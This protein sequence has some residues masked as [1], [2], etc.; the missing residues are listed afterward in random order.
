LGGV[1]RDRDQFAD[2]YRPV[3][4]ARYPVLL[5]RTPYN[6]A[7]AQTCVYQHPAWYA[8][9][10]YIV[11]VQDTR[12]RF[13]SGGSFE[14]Y[15][16]E[17]KDGVDTIAWASTLP[18]TT[19]QV[20]TYGFSY[21]GSNQLVA[22]GSNPKGLTSAAIGCAGSDFYDGWTYRG[23]ALQLAFVLSW[24]LHAFAVPD[25]LKAQDR[26]RA[27]WLRELGG[28]MRAAYERPLAHWLRSKQ[29]PNYFKDWVEHDTRDAYWQALAP[30]AT[31]GTINIP[32]LH[33]SGWYDIF[34]EGSIA[35]YCELRRGSGDDPSRQ[36]ALVIGPWQ[37]VPWA[38]LNGAVDYGWAGDN[39]VDQVQ[40][41][42]FDHWLK[43]KTVDPVFPTVRFFLLGANQWI[44]ADRWP[45]KGAYLF[46]LYLRSSGSAGTQLEDGGLS[47]EPP[48]EE[49][50][51]IFVYDPA[52]PVPSIGGSSCC[53]ADVAPIGVFDQR[54]VEIR[55]D[56]LVYTSA[57]LE[58][59][60]D[61]IG[62]LDLVLFAAS[63]AVDTD[64]TAKLVD[65]HPD[66]SALNVCD[67][68]IRARYRRSLE[69]STL[70]EPE[71]V[72]QYRISLRAIAMRFAAGLAMRLE[73]S[74][75]SFP[76]YNVNPNTGGRMATTDPLD[77][78]LATQLVF[79]DRH[80]QSRLR[81]MLAEGCHGPGVPGSRRG[82]GEWLNSM[83]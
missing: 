9:H 12:G 52:N 76:A 1:I 54:S 28:K 79:H 58:E 13:A 3:E 10:G 18:G 41:A 20:A 14:P 39:C 43:G 31:F 45:P 4:A 77:A 36:Q 61:V 42:W 5:Q 60:C 69:C 37:H 51:D 2:V 44:S 50:P 38:R 81:L 8:R 6:K 15:R 34:L 32:C 40:L 46:E 64:W 80:R 56:V 66:G 75:S 82:R 49:S 27:Q 57:K 68:I 29:L 48:A 67:G 65:V 62:P 78:R 23:G 19:G 22:A 71:K 63:D 30:S 7:F 74:S 83:R 26:S 53:R 25:A 73:I 11:V 17:G 35:N 72:Y 33:L 70:I 21:A 47:P 59:D 24:T 16:D 55:N